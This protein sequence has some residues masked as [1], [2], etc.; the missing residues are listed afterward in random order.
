[1]SRKGVV[2]L[3]V[4][5]G[6]A[7]GALYVYLFVNFEKK[8]RDAVS[9]E[10]AVWQ[11]KAGELEKKAGELEKEVK[12]LSEELQVAEQVPPPDAERHREAFGQA[13]PEQQTG[14]PG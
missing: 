13:E 8:T 10:R 12:K 6:L 7:A 1:M 5:L 3:I 2:I 9:Q 11:Q 14:E 4:L